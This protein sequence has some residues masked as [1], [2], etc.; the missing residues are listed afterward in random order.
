MC[1]RTFKGE[2]IKVWG[3]PLVMFT[4]SDDKK[5]KNKE[6]SFAIKSR[7]SDRL[8]IRR[9]TSLDIN[10]KYDGSDCKFI[11]V[12]AFRSLNN[13]GELCLTIDVRFLTKS[14]GHLLIPDLLQVTIK[15]TSWKSVESSLTKDM[16][17]LCASKEFA[18][19]EFI[20]NGKKIRAHK[21]VL[22][23]KNF[24]FR[25]IRDLVADHNLPQANLQIFS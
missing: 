4:S 14:S 18:D 5:I 24:F 9:N 22:A 1:P 6:F 21:F 10:K 15:D 3:R 20:V 7:N 2:D 13:N 17:D 11:D 16:R 12:A 23:G 19:F 8:S 25:L